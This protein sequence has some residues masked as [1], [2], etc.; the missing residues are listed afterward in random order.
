MKTNDYVRQISIWVSNLEDIQN[1]PL[2]LFESNR[3]EEKLAV[4]IDSINTRYGHH[5]IRNAYL[6]YSDKLTTKPN[7]FMADRFERMQIREL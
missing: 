6:L 5:T 4:T 7:G 2:S 3:K 1:T